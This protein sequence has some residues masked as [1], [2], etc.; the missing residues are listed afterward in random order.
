M[1]K[2]FASSS[3]I[4]YEVVLANG[5]V[6]NANRHS[7]SDLYWALKLGST[8]FGIVTQFEMEALSSPAIWG[9]VNM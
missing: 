4:N 7:H 1:G 5:T 2:G 3:I 8:N 6:V 9:M